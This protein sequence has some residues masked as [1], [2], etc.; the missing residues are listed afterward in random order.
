MRTTKLTSLSVFFP[1]YNEEGN[2]AEAIRRALVAIPKVAKKYEIIVVNDGS[3]DKTKQEAL[4]M[5]ARYPGVVRVVSQKNKGYGGA[6]KRGF[7]ESRYDWIF[8]TDADLQFDLQEITRLL[9]PAQTVDMVLGYRMK[10]ADGWKRILLAQ[11]LKIWN[12][13]WFNYPLEIKDT[14]CAF[15][16]IRR[17]VMKTIEPFISDGA[18][19]STELILKAQYANFSWKQVGVSHYLRLSG[20]PT[21]NN[22]R[23]IFRAIKDTFV[24]YRGLTPNNT[25]LPT[26]G[27]SQASQAVY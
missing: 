22:W 25:S 19:I 27:T 8:F 2:I 12:R 5:A 4:K 23:V 6:L 9:R 17:H 7:A 20:K 21:G 1:A 11:M 14:D 18:M 13:F 16:L 15:K 10:R 3:T 26:P 24:L